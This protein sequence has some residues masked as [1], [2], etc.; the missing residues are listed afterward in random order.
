MRTFVSGQHEHVDTKMATKNQLSKVYT[1]IESHMAI[2]SGTLS[3]S[4]DLAKTNLTNTISSVSGILD[5][6]DNQLQMALSNAKVQLSGYA[7]QKYNQTTQQTNQKIE[8]VNQTILANKTSLENKIIDEN[9][10]LIN[11]SSILANSNSTINTTLETVS[12]Q[13]SID[14]NTAKSTA[15]TYTDSK[16][17][18][19]NN[20]LALSSNFLDDTL[21]TYIN[22]QDGLIFNNSKEYVDQQISSLGNVFN[23]KGFY[24]INGEAVS[25][26]NLLPSNAA[27]GDV[28]FIN[29]LNANNIVETVQYV[30]KQDN[31]DI[32]TEKWQKFGTSVDLTNYSTKDYVET[33]KTQLLDTIQS[34][35]GALIEKYILANSNTL[36][37]T[38]TYTN[39]TL[40][41]R[42]TATSS[43][44]NEKS[45]KAYNDAKHYTDVQLETETLNYE[46]ADKQVLLSAKSYTDSLSLSVNTKLS[47]TSGYINARDAQI[48]LDAKAY[49]D[50]RETA[51]ETQIDNLDFTKLEEA[52]AY[53][54]IASGAFDQKLIETSGYINSRDTQ[55]LTDAKAY[56]DARETAILTTASNADA[57]VLTNAKAYTN[58]ASGAF[59]Q[60][61]IETSGYINNKDAQLKNYIDQKIAEL[62]STYQLASLLE[63]LE[64]SRN[65]T[66]N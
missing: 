10:L 61:L 42:L 34:V 33:R 20:L 26:I 7:D 24:Y 66:N 13:L 19:A 18:Q 40:E 59:D 48:L 8:D 56:T 29:E 31:T 9:T 25:S 21:R 37:D 36:E 16:F 43:Y 30:C 52:K 49:T 28:Y 38:K 60:K 53:T 23:V 35:S 32:A 11:V 46:N 12:G 6:Q 17:E 44:I 1:K 47:S 58:A 62:I 22:Q 39:N 2:V 51:I 3:S 5:T 54:N 65:N 27:I 4:I 64:N 55:V 45:T 14:I 41:T 15:N 63:L 50:A 57:T